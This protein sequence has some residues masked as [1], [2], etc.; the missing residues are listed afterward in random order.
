MG[1]VDFSDSMTQV[2]DAQAA[3]SLEA[4][5]RGF[6]PLH[7]AQGTLMYFSVSRRAQLFFVESC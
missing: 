1:T 4:F 5:K 2:D 6:K 3:S 7:Q